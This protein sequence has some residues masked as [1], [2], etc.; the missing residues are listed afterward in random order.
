MYIPLVLEPLHHWKWYLT[1]RTLNYFDFCNVNLNLDTWVFCFN[2]DIEWFG[3][4]QYEF[5]FW[6]LKG[7]GFKQ[8]HVSVV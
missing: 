2:K 8:M 7:I 6:I 5:T 4:F 3:F 1:T